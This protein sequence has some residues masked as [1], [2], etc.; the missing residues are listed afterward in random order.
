MK[1]MLLAAAVGL[2]LAAS[3][4]AYADGGDPGAFW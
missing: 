4:V 2:S 3:T 1:T